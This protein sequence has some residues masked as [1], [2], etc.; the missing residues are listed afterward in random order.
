MILLHAVSYIKYKKN[1]SSHMQWIIKH[2]SS[3][4]QEEED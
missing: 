2:I 4:S 3:N 1:V